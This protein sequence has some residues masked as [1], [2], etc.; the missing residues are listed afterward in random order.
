MH[1]HFGFPI[2]TL[3]L[4]Q[5]PENV[6]ISIFPFTLFR[7]KCY[8]SRGIWRILK[9]ISLAERRERWLL[10]LRISCAQTFSFCYS[11][12]TTFPSY[13]KCKNLNFSCYTVPPEMLL[14][15]KYLTNFQKVFFTWKKR[16]VSIVVENFKC[17]DIL[18][19][20][21]ATLQFFHHPENVKISIYPFT[22]SRQKS[23]ISRSI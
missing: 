19:F 10:P 15:Q 2:A 1:R 16:K 8:I 22:L 9:N 12:V 17:T 3:R 20:T 18:F 5:H 13:R 6:K 4:F 7:Q 11:N 14:V 23:Y 21:I